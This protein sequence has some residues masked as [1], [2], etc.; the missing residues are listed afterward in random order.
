[1]RAAIALRPELTDAWFALGHVLRRLGRMDESEAAHRFV[2]EHDPASPEARLALATVLQHLQRWDEAEAMLLEVIARAPDHAGALT[3]L[4][5]L[6]A[7]RGDTEQGETVLRRALALRPGDASL[8]TNLGMIALATGRFEEGWPLYERRHEFGEVPPPDFPFPLWRK[9]DLRGKSLLV[10]SEQGFGDVLQMLRYV[11]QLRERGLTRLVWVSKSPLHALL[12]NVPGIDEVRDASEP[13][14]LCDCWCFAMSLPIHFD[15]NL[16]NMAARLPYLHVPADHLAKWKPR[17]PAAG[18]R[19]GIAW[20][21]ASGHANDSNRSLSSLAALAPLW[22]VQGIT[23]ISLQKDRGEEE[24]LSP[25]AGQRLLALGHEFQDLADTAAVISML[26]LVISVDTS[27]VHLAGAMGKPVWVMLPYYGVDW[28]WLKNRDDSPWYPSVMRLFRAT[29]E[30]GWPGLVEAVRVELDRKMMSESKAREW[31]TKANAARR[32]GRTVDAEAAYRAAIELVPNAGRFHSNLGVLLRASGRLPEAEAQYRL[33]IEG[34]PTYAEAHANLGNLLRAANRAEESEASYRAAI[35]ARPDLISG[36]NGL[37]ALMMQ[38]KRRHEAEAAFRRA[39]EIDPL[40]AES[41]NN[42]GTMMQD[43]RR[44][45][46]SEAAYARALQLKPDFADASNNL[47]VLLQKAGRTQEAQAI[48]D[49]AKKLQPLDPRF[50]NNEAALLVDAKEW[51]EAEKAY[52]RALELKPDYPDAHNNLGALLHITNRPIEAEK[53][54]REA[55]RL[56]PGSAETQLNLGS[57]LLTEGRLD[58]GWPLYEARYSAQLGDPTVVAPALPCPQWR[59]E[60]LQGKSIIL[61]PEQGFGDSIQFVRYAPMLKA[62]G[63]TRITVVVNPPLKQVLDKVE[64]VDDVVI[65][66]RTL[67]AHDYWTFPLSL[68]MRFGTTLDSIL[69]QLPYIRAD[70]QRLEKWKARL[71][72][73]KL[74]IGLVWKGAAGHK[75]DMN[76]SIPSLATLAPLWSIPGASF[77]SLQKGQGEDE[78]AHPPQGQPITALGHD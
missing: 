30:H 2:V 13:L 38:L 7:L 29:A 26:D 78:A 9:E 25:P 4:G 33:A 51:D 52:R 58:E 61:W 59:G 54:L 41:W 55:L 76:R 35:A 43:A 60:S 69:A 31:F 77:V 20:R 8:K 5:T 67:Q 75:N 42:L 74:K 73:S 21:G 19:V 16:S 45:K 17:I 37:G 6:L 47:G 64:G 68:P 40:H 57:L 34:E 62:L 11:P 66:L 27:L 63:A 70:A 18:L 36:W 48:Y 10:W 56:N 22:R 12:A 44:L 15:A 14:P 3:K 71:P 24:A 46:E 50:A 72:K 28:R 23:F 53:E 49:K 32:E 39:V 1:L 65:D